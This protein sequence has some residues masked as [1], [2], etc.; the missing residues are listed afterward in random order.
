MVSLAVDDLDAI[1]SYSIASDLQM[2]PFLPV[3]TGSYHRKKWSPHFLT[4][5]FVEEHKGLELENYVQS[6]EQLKHSGME[7]SG[8]RKQFLEK[9]A[10]VVEE[11]G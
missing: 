7:I 3:S 6:S 9:A 8:L 4:E 1:K 11:E 5:I 10:E 2:A